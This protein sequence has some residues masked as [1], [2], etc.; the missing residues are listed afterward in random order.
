MERVIDVGTGACF[1]GIPLKIAC[2]AM[3]LTLVESVGKKAAFCQHM[4]ETL[5]LKEVEVVLGRAETVGVNPAHREGYDWAVAR[6]VASMPVLMEYLLPLARVGGYA[7]AMKG[8]SAPAE[9]QAAQGAMR[10][11][12]GELKQLVPVTLP[13]VED[14]RYLVVIEKRAAT[15]DRYPRR[16]GVPAKRPL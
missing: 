5:R 13:G 1:P 10:L 3:R 6:A 7:L 11:L 4:A 8:E 16:V 15:P 14:Q 2:P 9:V 12:G